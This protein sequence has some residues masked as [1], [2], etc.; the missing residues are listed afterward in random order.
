MVTLIKESIW[1]RLAY[2]SQVTVHKTN[3][4]ITGSKVA[5]R[6]TWCWRLSDSSTTGFIGRK[7]RERDSGHALSTWNTKVHP[8]Y[9][10][11]SN[12]NTTTTKSHTPLIVPF[13]GGQGFQYMSLW[14]PFQLKSLLH[15]YHTSSESS[16]QIFIMEKH[17]LAQCRYQKGQKILPQ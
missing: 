11:T 15:V 13:P 7:K 17:S 8:K 16:Q 3:A 10:T 4:V 12:K 9:H 1:L 14:G 6:Q 5:C 2:I